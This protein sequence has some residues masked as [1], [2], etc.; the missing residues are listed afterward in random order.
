M[1]EA[2]SRLPKEHSDK[3]TR[4][5]ERFL[6][7]ES[8]GGA[9]ILSATVMALVVAN[10]PWSSAFDRIWNIP[11][12]I[13]IGDL[14]FVHTL[15]HLINDGL[16]TLFFFVIALELKRE[17]VLGE[18]SGLKVAAL[19]IAGAIGGMLVPVG[20]FLAIVG[21]GQGAGGWGTVMSTDT[22]F[23][24]ACL[25]LLGRRVPGSLRVFLLSLA[26]FDDIGAIMV[27][28]IGYGGGLNGFALAAGAIG[29]II[30]AIV[31]F[32]GIRSLAIYF[33][34]GTGIWLALDASGIH[35]TI[36]GVL[37]GLMAPTRSWVSDKRLHVILGKVMS[38]PPGVDWKGSAAARGALRRARI[39]TRE[40]LSPVERLET[41]LH[42]WVAFLVL[43]LF[44]L[45]NAGIQL[46]VGDIDRRL[47]AAIFFAFS[48]G[49][50]LGVFVFC[51]LAVKW[52]L[53]VLPERLSW[54]QLFG[55]GVLTGIGFTMSFL[56]AGI[57]FESTALASVKIGVLLASIT[58]A[59]LGVAW[60]FLLSNDR[61]SA[62]ESARCE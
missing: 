38:F 26:I 49:K 2:L 34:I 50:P 4:L 60:L 52:G 53:A 14:H 55:G 29:C 43:P 8:M 23:V 45:A 37:L 6:R 13:H 10:S 40:A 61:A 3:L 21:A 42:P 32:L 27:V 48:V 59:V 28:A 11:I 62:H 46:G 25:A 36:T 33:A 58:A 47:A 7:V 31:S 57:S 16:M 51:Y 30:V 20:I 56:I 12:E 44:A 1:I 5:F 41:A 9:A 15:K 17:I 35:A 19:P 22:A 39:A 24:V 54:R 18:L